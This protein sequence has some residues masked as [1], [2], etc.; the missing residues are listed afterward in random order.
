VLNFLKESLSYTTHMVDP[1]IYMTWTPAPREG[2]LNNDAQ[3]PA[4]YIWLLGYLAKAVVAQCDK[5]VSVNPAAAD[6]I[7]VFVATIFSN[8]PLLWRGESLIDIL[9]S[10]FRMSCPALFGLRGND[11]TEQGRA[12]LGWKRDKS[13]K[14]WCND[15]EHTARM[16]GIA[17]GYAAISLRDFSRTKFKN[18]WPPSKYWMTLASICNTPADETSN[19]QFTVLKAIISSNETRFIG[20][21]GTAGKAALKLALVDFPIRANRER[22]VNVAADSLRT[23]ASVLERD[24]SLVLDAESGKW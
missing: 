19:T 17:A 18:P 16:S 5:E 20:F 8:T 11:K 2:A 12:R 7:G 4:V 3:L 15:E 6:P 9:M 22:G 21:Y 24:H 14:V 10:K 13:T 23:V 1:S